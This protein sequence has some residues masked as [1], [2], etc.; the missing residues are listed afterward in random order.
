LIPKA[1]Q[2]W[3]ARFFYAEVLNGQKFL[4]GAKIIPIKMKC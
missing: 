2:L 3:L 4:K 1:R